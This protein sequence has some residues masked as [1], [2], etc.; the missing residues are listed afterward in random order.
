MDSRYSDYDLITEL[1]GLKKDNLNIPNKNIC[2]NCGSEMEHIN[3]TGNYCKICGYGDP[4]INYKEIRKGRDIKLKDMCEKTQIPSS[5]LSLIENKKKAIS[6]QQ[7]K[8]FA[9]AIGFT[10]DELINRDKPRKLLMMEEYPGYEG[11]IFKC[12]CCMNTADLN[13]KE[14]LTLGPTYYITAKI[15][16]L[17]NDGD[18]CIYC[19]QP[20]IRPVKV[21]ENKVKKNFDIIYKN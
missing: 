5:T 13:L 4:E 17:G 11:Y 19:G 18:Y 16:S 7:L 3:N 10:A 12:P 6:K 9:K 14:A 1:S 8:S 21:N 15:G 20:L 2:P